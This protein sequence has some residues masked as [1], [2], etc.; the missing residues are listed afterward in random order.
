MN[1]GLRRDAAHLFRSSR[2]RLGRLP[3]CCCTLAANTDGITGQHT[4]LGVSMAGTTDYD[5][6]RRNTLEDDVD[7]ETLHGLTAAGAEKQSPVVDL[8]DGDG[9]D[10]VEL[11]DADPSGE[12]LTMPVV[13]RKADEFTCTSCFL[14][15]HRSRI[16]SQSGAP[17]ICIDCA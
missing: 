15:Q 4:V 11:P 5:A 16:A 14:V 3:F 7:A 6:P 9:D 12:V 10:G 2:R 13:P 1:G 8:D 17:P